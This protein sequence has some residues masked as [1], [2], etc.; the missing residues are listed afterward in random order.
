LR[1]LPCV[2][3][4]ARRLGRGRAMSVTLA[5]GTLRFALVA[6]EPAVRGCGPAL[7]SAL[8]NGASKTKR[9]PR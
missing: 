1:G 8:Q 4:L 7:G 5:T 2:A 9:S 6:S 3:Q